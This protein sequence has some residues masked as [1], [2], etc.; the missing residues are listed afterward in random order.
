MISTLPLWKNI[1]VVKLDPFINNQ[2]EIPQK[3]W[4]RHPA[5]SEKSSKFICVVACGR[6]VPHDASKIATET[7]QRKHGLRLSHIDE[8]DFG[9]NCEKKDH[10]QKLVIHT[11]SEQIIQLPPMYI[12]KSKSGVATS[13]PKSRLGFIC[14]ELKSSV[15]KPCQLYIRLVRCQIHVRHGIPTVL[16]DKIISWVHVSC[17]TGSHQPQELNQFHLPS[18]CSL[19]LFDKNPGIKWS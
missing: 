17:E 16:L 14:W 3:K 4:N 7:L 6:Y 10:A 11:C 9:R 19:S 5:N 8:Y 15:R 1:T 18:V 12:L 2:V 13:V